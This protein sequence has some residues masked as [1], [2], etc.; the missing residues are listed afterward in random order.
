MLQY[1]SKIVKER[2]FDKNRMNEKV[3][4]C[5]AND[6]KIIKNFVE[7]FKRVLIKDNVY[8]SLNNPRIREKSIK[9]SWTFYQMPKINK[10]SNH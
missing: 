4:S 5:K 7:M 8:V 10:T 6:R 1:E 3:V 2:T 9:N